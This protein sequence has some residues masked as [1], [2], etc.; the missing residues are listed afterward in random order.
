M[1]VIEAFATPIQLTEHPQSAAFHQRLTAGMKELAA[2]TPS[3]DDF[4]AHRG[5][6]YT[7]GDLFENPSDDV[8]VVMRLIQQGL[9]DYYEA[10]GVKASVTQTGIQG[11]AALTT[12]G[13]Y[14]TPH[15]HAGATISGVYYAHVPDTLEEPEGAIDFITPVDVQESTFLK[16]YSKSYCRVVPKSG[17]LLIFP[18][19]LRH[20]THPIRSGGDRLAIVF[21]AFT[22]Q[23]R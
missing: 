18:S 20:F 4:R 15:L 22:K 2:C 21:N 23:G 5:G 19:Y 6:F 9:E 8:K 17:S 12:V 10:L 7:D 1:P 3:S 14:Q 13:D 16:G 11:W